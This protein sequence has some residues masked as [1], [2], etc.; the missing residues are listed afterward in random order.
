MQTRPELFWDI[1]Q[2]IEVILAD[3]AVQPIDPILK[4]LSVPSSRIYRS[5]LQGPLKMVTIGCPE[6]SVSNYH[7]TLQN[8]PEERIS[9][10]AVMLLPEGTAVR[11]MSR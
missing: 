1:T 7:Y 10:L 11:S 4:N 9:H 2:R 5:R 6:M 8:T 3:V